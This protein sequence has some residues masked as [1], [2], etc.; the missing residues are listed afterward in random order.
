MGERRKLPLRNA[1]EC[2]QM[3]I[4]ASAL[5]DEVTFWA[6]EENYL[7]ALWRSERNAAASAR[8]EAGTVRERLEHRVHVARVAQVG[9]PRA[10]GRQSARLSSVQY[11]RLL[12]HRRRLQ[13]E[14]GELCAEVGEPG[15]VAE[16]PVVA[17]VAVDGLADDVDDALVSC[18][19]RDVVV[20]AVAAAELRVVGLAA[21]AHVAA[22]ETDP[23][24]V[25][26]GAD[27]A[28]PMERVVQRDE[29]VAARQP[30]VR[31]AAAHACEQERAAAA[32]A[33]GPSFPL[34]P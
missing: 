8:A 12:A 9:E 24:A 31:A 23:H 29:R 32:C 22:L 15:L 2:A 5:E 1:P 3:R 6:A 27:L 30:D 10:A 14:R 28:G 20:A 17:G 16:H 26:R 33:G 11:A 25:G 21:A 34:S 7:W 13:L 4:W 18:A 19:A